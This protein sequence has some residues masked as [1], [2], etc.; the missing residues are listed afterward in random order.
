MDFG[1][2]GPNGFG[3]G[4]ADSWAHWPLWPNIEMDFALWA[5]VWANLWTRL[6]WA[7]IGQLGQDY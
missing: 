4:F 7:F 1:P 5:S 6:F 3:H 2:L